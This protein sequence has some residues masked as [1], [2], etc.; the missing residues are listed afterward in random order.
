[1]LVDGAFPPIRGR[2]GTGRLQRIA[3][4]YPSS[5]TF[6]RRLRSSTPA[7]LRLGAGSDGAPQTVI[8][9][10]HI[11][12]SRI[13]LSCSNMVD[14]F[15]LSLFHAVNAAHMQRILGWKGGE[16]NAKSRDTE[17]GKKSL[18]GENNRRPFP[19]CS[20]ASGQHPSDGGAFSAGRSGATGV[21][22]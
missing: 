18:E 13:S 20:C 2:T 8:E 5:S 1:M 10:P 7:T 4:L 19:F 3:C 14:R 22:Q 17:G 15:S 6:G 16:N 11:F 21:L 9:F 12:W